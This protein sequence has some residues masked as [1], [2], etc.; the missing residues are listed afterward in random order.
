MAKERMKLEFEMD[1]ALRLLNRIVRTYNAKYNHQ[2]ALALALTI[3]SVA[4]KLS[5]TYVFLKY[6]SSNW[7]SIIYKLITHTE[8]TSNNVDVKYVMP[9]P[10]ESLGSPVIEHNFTANKRDDIYS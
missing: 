6:I 9:Q 3:R 1:L 5:T 10:L 8:R 4:L 7:Y 2:M